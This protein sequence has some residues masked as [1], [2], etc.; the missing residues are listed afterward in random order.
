MDGDAALYEVTRAARGVEARMSDIG[1]GVTVSELESAIRATLAWV[2]AA[3]DL[4]FMIGTGLVRF[5][6]EA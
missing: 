6:T 2:E 3:S 1:P 4:K 5:S